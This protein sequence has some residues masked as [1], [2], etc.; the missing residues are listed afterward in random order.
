MKRTEAIEQLQNCIDLIKQDG[1]D[2]LDDRD[3]PLLNMAIEA[4]KEQEISNELQEYAYEC[5]YEHFFHECQNCEHRRIENKADK[6]IPITE[7]EP[8]TSDHVLVTYKWDDDDYET[9]EL[10]YWVNKYEAEHGN[11]RCR[12][13]HDHIIAWQLKPMPYRETD[14]EWQKEE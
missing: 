12:F 2:Y 10:D 3:I 5:G 8:N 6:W 13:F 11:E 9:S 4:L 7:A 14:F 1:Q